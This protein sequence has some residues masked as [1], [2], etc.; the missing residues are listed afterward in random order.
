MSKTETLTPVMLTFWQYS[1]RRSQF[2]QHSFTLNRDVFVPVPV[3]EPVS[4]LLNTTGDKDVTQ[5]MKIAQRYGKN[6]LSLEN[7]NSKFSD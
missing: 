6:L 1:H 7:A 5:R 3:S 4:E 2:I